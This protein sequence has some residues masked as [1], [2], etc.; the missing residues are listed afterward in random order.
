M[1]FSLVRS[2]YASLSPV[3]HLAP[4]RR[5]KV[6]PTFPQSQNIAVVSERDPP[7]STPSPSTGRAS[8][9]APR[10]AARRTEV[11]EATRVDS[12]DLIVVGFS[13]CRIVLLCQSLGPSDQNAKHSQ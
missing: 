6:R 1:A 10:T 3:P 9:R 13:F 7:V 8:R 4:T 12:V 11:Q 2:A 5:K